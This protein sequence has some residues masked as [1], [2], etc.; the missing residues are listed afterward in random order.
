MREKLWKFFSANSQ[1]KTID[2]LVKDRP[3]RQLKPTKSNL[4]IC[5]SNSLSVSHGAAANKGRRVSFGTIKCFPE[6][7]APALQDQETVN[8]VLVI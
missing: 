3:V 2:S 7:Y 5:N 4:D 6:Q 1:P 8:D